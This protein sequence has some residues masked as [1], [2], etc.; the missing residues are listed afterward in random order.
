MFCPFCWSLNSK[1]VCLH[2]LCDETWHYVRVFRSIFQISL[3]AK[4]GLALRWSQSCAPRV[5]SWQ[6]S[7]WMNT[8]ELY[9]GLHQAVPN[10]DRG[11]L[12][13]G[14]STFRKTAWPKRTMKI[15][16]HNHWATSTSLFGLLR[17]IFMHHL[18]FLLSNLLQH[19]LCVLTTCNSVCK[20]R[21]YKSVNLLTCV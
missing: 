10:K 15:S 13:T 2:T 12:L 19:W 11:T 18:A 17:R 16:F 14:F 3:Y 8:L 6:S 5:E 9:G 20:R 21:W 4:S 7:L 1:Y